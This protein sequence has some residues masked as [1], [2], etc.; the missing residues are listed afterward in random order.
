MKL[1]IVNLILS[2]VLLS[3]LFYV[4]VTSSIAVYDPYADYDQDGDIDIYDIV[5]AASN[6]GESW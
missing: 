5:E 4:G 1:S 6:Y 3:S 2:I